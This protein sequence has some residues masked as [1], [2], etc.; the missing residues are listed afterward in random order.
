GHLRQLVSQR[1]EDKAEHLAGVRQRLGRVHPRRRF[2]D[3][4]QQLYD[5][6]NGLARCGKKGVQQHRAIWRDLSA[7]LAR[8]RP[9]LLLKRRGEV[10]WQEQERLRE[11]VRHHLQRRRTQLK[12]IESSLR[13]LGPQQ[14]LAR[15]YSI[16][17]DAE[18][19]R[20]LRAA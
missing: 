10:L 16:T 2:N 19:G 17:M 1:L 12:A 18:S 9:A 8:V 3:W 20:I 11:Q 13:L 4:L 5:L 6:Q 7:R 14:V 15:G